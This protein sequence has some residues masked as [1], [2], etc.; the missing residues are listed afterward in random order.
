MARTTIPWGDGSG[1]NIYLDYPAASG[2]QTIAVS[3]DALTGGARTKVVTFS[4]SGVTPVT[5]TVKQAPYDAEVEYLQSDGSSYIDTG[6]NIRAIVHAIMTITFPEIPTG[7]S[8][9]PAI[10]GAYWDASPRVPRNQLT[11]NTSGK[12]TVVQN[13]SVSG[14]TSG[15][16]AVAGIDYNLDIANKAAQSSDR[17]M[18]VM[19]RNNDGGN[20][21]I[22]DFMRLKSL[23]MTSAGVTVLDCIPVRV[24]TVGYLYDS[25]GSRLIGNAGG[26][27]FIVG[28]DKTT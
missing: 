13:T 2:D 3:S 19:A 27:A 26:G 21:N 4:A 8:R 12:W 18:Y 28:P 17:T 11:L 6:V 10:Y 24:G 1:D 14:A 15:A 5:L 20:Y 25:V 9:S 16:A 7:L 22:C 23:R